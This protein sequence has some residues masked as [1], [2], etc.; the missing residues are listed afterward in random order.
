MAQVVKVSLRMRSDPGC[1]PQSGFRNKKPARSK[2][3]R[4]AQ[5]L[6]GPPKRK[7][8]SA[9]ERDTIMHEAMMHVMAKTLRRLSL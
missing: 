9:R 3:E 4:V 6:A 8:M 2:E 7:N 1:R 5:A